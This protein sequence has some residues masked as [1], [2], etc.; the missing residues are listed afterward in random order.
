[1]EA[2]G[3]EPLTIEEF[4]DGELRRQRTGVNYA[5]MNAAYS[6]WDMN[7]GNS[8]DRAPNGEPSILFQT[9]LEKYDGDTM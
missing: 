5:A 2:L 9:L 8:I 3:G 1:M 4:K 6:I 7:N